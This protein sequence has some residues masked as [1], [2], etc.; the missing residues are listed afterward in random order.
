MEYK[1][2]Y[3]I[4]YVKDIDRKR[5]KIPKERII[6]NS[7]IF[8]DYDIAKGCRCVKVEITYWVEL[9]SY[10]KHLWFKLDDFNQYYKKCENYQRFK[11]I[12]KINNLAA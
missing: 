3:I 10:T 2:L 5:F 11:K 8:F 9:R 1:M 4:D 12:S 7:S 6:F